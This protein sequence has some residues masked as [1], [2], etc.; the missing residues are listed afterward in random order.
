MGGHTHG[1]IDPSLFSTERGIRAVKVS[2]V[3]LMVTALL[4]VV[5]VYFTGSVALLADTIHNFG[6]ALTAIPL[7]I[8]FRLGGRKPDR[9]YTYGYGR[10]EDLAGAV[11]VLMIAL[12]AVFVAWESVRRLYEPQAIEYLWA[13]GLAAIIGFIGNEIVARYRISVG[14]AIG[15]AAL[16][17][18]GYHARADGLTSLAVLAGAIGVWLGFTLADPLIGLV[19]TIV[20]LRIA[21]R[22]GREVFSRMLDGVDPAV[23]DEI[24]HATAHVPGVTAVT[25]IAVRWLGHRMRAEL[26]IAVDPGLTVVAGHAIASTVNHE[27]LH[28]LPYL[29]SA[30]IHVDPADTAAGHHRISDHAHDDLAPHTHAG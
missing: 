21:W 19:I 5:V 22:S 12:S 3:V 16:I 14:K 6:D 18:D 1:V 25:N 2:L 27:L 30:V 10:A 4:Q 24:E 11:I 13:V 8:A 17:A 26:S 20:I 15:S 28:H 23:V 7:W 9:R 29:S